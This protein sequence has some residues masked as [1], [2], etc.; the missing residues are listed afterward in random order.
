MDLKFWVAPV[1][2]NFTTVN[3]SKRAVNVTWFPVTSGNP[4]T[5]TTVEYRQLGSHQWRGVRAEHDHETWA[6]VEGLASGVIYEMRVVARDGNE[7][8]SRTAA[9][10]VKKVRIG[11]K[12][13][14]LQPSF[15]ITYP[16]TTTFGIELLSHIKAVDTYYV[17]YRPIGSSDWRS[18]QEVVKASWITVRNLVPGTTYEVQL[19]AKDERGQLLSITKEAIAGTD[20]D[21]QASV[22]TQYGGSTPQQATLNVILTSLV[23]LLSTRLHQPVL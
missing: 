21:A 2:P 18:T 22:G 15:K 23:A 7:A 1:A 9:S 8:G 13:D 4:G 3:I 10:P 5:V 6:V 20:P 11:M 14:V 12:R 17:K 16:D 19:V